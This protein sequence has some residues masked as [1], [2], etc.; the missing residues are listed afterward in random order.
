MDL[1]F[2][3]HCL[4]LLVSRIQKYYVSMFTLSLYQYKQN[5]TKLKALVVY[6]SRKWDVTTQ[7][8][9]CEITWTPWCYYISLNYTNKK[10]KSNTYTFR[11]YTAIYS[12]CDLP[13]AS[14]LSK[15]V[16]PINSRNCYRQKRVY[17]VSWVVGAAAGGDFLGLCEQKLS[18]YHGSYSQ[19]WVFFQF[20]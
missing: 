8:L 12:S 2:I 20:S 17:G 11:L 4:V 1:D 10:R 6:L 16:L 13:L 5:K 7:A 3:P 9:P 15:H 18:I 14:S 19:P